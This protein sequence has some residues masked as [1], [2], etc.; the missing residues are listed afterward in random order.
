[1]R[2]NGSLLGMGSSSFYLLQM[3]MI[4]EDQKKD[5]KKARRIIQHVWIDK[6]SELRN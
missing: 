6:K 4:T 5:K 3:K 2:K 1:M